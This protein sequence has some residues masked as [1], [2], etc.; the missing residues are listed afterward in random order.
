MNAY[1]LN[2]FHS[3]SSV[4]PSLFRSLPRTPS[5]P[6]SPLSSLHKDTVSW[7]D[8]TAAS[9][10]GTNLCVVKQQQKNLCVALTPNI[11]GKPQPLPPLSLHGCVTIL[12]S[13]TS[14]SFLPHFESSHS[15]IP[16]TVLLHWYFRLMGKI[17]SAR[18]SQI[19]EW[20]RF[21]VR[22]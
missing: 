12:C 2:L 21:W 1:S 3:L 14:H 16:S 10:L 11:L 5:W 18:L 6:Q 13:Q 9:F 4:P 7:D 22:I 8:V 20:Q 19:Q 15:L 17:I